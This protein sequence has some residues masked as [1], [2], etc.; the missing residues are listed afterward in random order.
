VPIPV[1]ITK[2]TV[3]NSLKSIIKNYNDHPK[4]W[5]AEESKIEGE[6]ID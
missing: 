6:L 1:P 3:A 2:Q 4:D 5:D